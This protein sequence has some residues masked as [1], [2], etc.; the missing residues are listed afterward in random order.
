LSLF[1]E[2]PVSSLLGNS[3]LPA[4]GV[5]GNAEDTKEDRASKPG[6]SAARGIRHLLFENAVSNR[7]PGLLPRLPV[8]PRVSD[9]VFGRQH[10]EQF[11]ADVRR[12]GRTAFAANDGSDEARAV[13]GRP[14]AAR[15]TLDYGPLG[16][17]P[18]R[19]TEF[20]Y[21]LNCV[22]RWYALDYLHG[23][24]SSWLLFP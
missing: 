16:A 4:Y 6:P 13:E 23:I 22:V 9:P 17:P 10:V 5:L 1:T 18:V 24:T 14:L 21:F 7:Y 11:F 20:V 8:A 19:S 2:R 12:A 3:G 15:P